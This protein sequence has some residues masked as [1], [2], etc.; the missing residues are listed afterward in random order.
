MWVIRLNLECDKWKSFWSTDTWLWGKCGKNI[1]WILTNCHFWS[2]NAAWLSGS[3]ISWTAVVELTTKSSCSLF[4][5][6]LA[7][8][9][10]LSQK[11]F[12]VCHLSPSVIGRS[13][14][15]Q[16]AEI[17]V[18]REI[19]LQFLGTLSSTLFFLLTSSFCR[20][21]QNTFDRQQKSNNI[22]SSLCISE[23]CVLWNVDVTIT[24]FS[25]SSLCH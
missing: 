16:S 7:I 18:E 19:M 5:W 11:S 3:V 17:R 2:E 14:G 8:L 15:R 22:L 25:T 12:C 20:G 4:R 24:S 1:S 23:G 9:F 21:N 6:M 13:I 10:F